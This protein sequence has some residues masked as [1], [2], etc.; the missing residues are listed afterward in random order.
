[1]LYL[2]HILIAVPNVETAATQLTKTL[3]LVFAPPSYHTGS[4]TYNRMARFANGTS[5]E[6]LGISDHDGV[7]RIADIEHDRSYFDNG[8]SQFGFAL[9]TDDM[10][11]LLAHAKEY[12]G[13][14]SEPVYGEAKM[15]DDSVRAW[16]GVHVLQLDATQF[17][18]VP[19]V[20]QYT[21]GWGPEVWRPQGLLEHEMDYH[22]I[23]GVSLTAHQEELDE[24]YMRNFGLR[25]TTEGSDFRSHYPLDDNG[26][27][28]PLPDSQDY[29]AG[30]LKQFYPP[31]V[32]T[33]FIAVPD[34][35]E[36]ATKLRAWQVQT[37]EQ[38]EGERR[39]IRIDPQAT[40]GLHFAL[41]NS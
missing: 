2:D 18:V 41:I 25:N 16:Q 35:Y 32:H 19:F 14:L 5:I 20:I 11:Q 40:L 33:T 22:G 26:F 15:P 24:I 6:L 4:V 23:V 1:M 37:A 17:L 31:Q 29:V 13:R 28:A 36:A 7:A 30:S 27:I 9:R 3:G 38:H 12:E 34:L 21:Q 39:I 8:P 10:Q